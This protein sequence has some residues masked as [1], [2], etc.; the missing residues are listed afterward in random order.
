MKCRAYKIGIPVFLLLL[1]RKNGS[2]EL[3]EIPATLSVQS[4]PT[5]LPTTLCCE[6][7]G[8][9][10]W[11]EELGSHRM[12]MNNV[13]DIFVGQK[14]TNTLKAS[15]T[16]ARQLL[17]LVGST[18]SSQENHERSMNG[19]EKRHEMNL[20]TRSKA[21]VD[22]LLAALQAA[23]ERMGLGMASAPGTPHMDI[24]NT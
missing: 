24:Y 12:A 2:E 20:K 1:Q 6:A 15:S 23:F 21:E 14:I 9:K 4:G 7:R 3:V 8:A 17:A 10:G 11:A 18:T 5:G 16:P 19:M 13:A 22:I